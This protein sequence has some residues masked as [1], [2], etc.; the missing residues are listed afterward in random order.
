[1][2][3]EGGRGLENPGT[4]NSI[5][6]AA[7]GPRSNGA[8]WRVSPPLDRSPQ[9]CLSQHR[10]TARGRQGLLSLWTGESAKEGTTANPSSDPHRGGGGGGLEAEARAGDGGGT[11]RGQAGPQGVW[12]VTP[13][14]GGLGSVPTWPQSSLGGSARAAPPLLLLGHQPSLSLDS[15]RAAPALGSPLTQLSLLLSEDPAYGYQLPF[16]FVEEWWWL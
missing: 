11:G 13:R 16:A 15:S 8:A 12:G 10:R 3:A 9:P 14:E 2:H 1:M 7:R 5:L 4:R 6:T